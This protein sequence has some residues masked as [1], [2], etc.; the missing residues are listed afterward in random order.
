MTD[1][2]VVG[3]GPNGLV[4][5]NLLADRGWSVIVFEEQPD[6][7]GAVRS[8]DTVEPAFTSDR[9]SAFYPLAVAS[10]V[11]RGLEL[12]RWGLSWERSEAAVAHPLA[13]GSCALLST[14]VDET[15]ASLDAYADGDGDA[16]RRLYSRWEQ[17]GEAIIEAL[18]T[19]FPP[20]RASA[21][22]ATA[23]RRQLVDFGRFAL[24]PVR[25]LAEETFRGAG[26]AN[27]LAGNALHADL[28]PDAIGGGLFGWLLCGL[29]QQYGF[30]V[31]RGGAGRLT[32]ALAD[33]LRDRGGEIH[34]G[35][36]VAAIT[37]SAGRA[38]G[39]ML[40]DGTTV[41]ARRA[42]LADTGAP[43]LYEELLP[44]DC[45]P[46]RL[47]SRMRSF[48]Y[49]SSTIKIDWALDRPIPW[50]AEAASRAGTVHV[51]DGLDA[52]TDT[53][54]KIAMGEI[55]DRPFLVLGQYSMV[56]AS[57]APTGKESAWAYT[58][59]P[60]RTRRDAGGS[61]QGRW[62]ASELD[63]FTGRMENE[64]ERL[65]PGFRS[66]IRGRS[67]S[68]PRELEAANRNLVG[69]AINSGTAQLHQQ[70]MF[71]PVAGAGRAETP[72]RGCYLAS[73]SAH[74]GGG[75]HGGPGSN[76]ARAALFHDRVNRLRRR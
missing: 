59:V 38:S 13:D 37:V 72:V 24:L 45:V 74:P 17:T 12:E 30:P 51:A 20:I 69:G 71:R 3:S 14:D 11:L 34:C 44:D 55:P 16:W 61:L 25:R 36:R 40:E 19:P 7:G 15:S 64:V 22:L 54:A 63:Q 58:H 57:R 1:A 42:V 28:T 10:P 70:L 27:L 26:G 73:A 76:A 49:D 39:V 6:P 66:S 53:T 33:R 43:Q 18:L 67:I 75:V 65:A 52:L 29:G 4:A 60:Q 32:D 21:R 2:V 48:Q 47:R 50:T 46:G 23:L 56:D 31:P 9:F 68:G 62:D 8:A 35:Q 41:A 5:A